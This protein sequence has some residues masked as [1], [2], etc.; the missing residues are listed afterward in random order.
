M[1]RTTVLNHSQTGN[2]FHKKF[3]LIVFK[4][5]YRAIIRYVK[6]PNN[7]KA[8]ETS[9]KRKNVKHAKNKKNVKHAKNKKKCY[10]QPKNEKVLNIRNTAVLGQTS[11]M[12]K[13]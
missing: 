8:L 5:K 9:E 6:H 12:L 4:I 10:K 13:K 7:E 11:D 3:F 2:C 1:I